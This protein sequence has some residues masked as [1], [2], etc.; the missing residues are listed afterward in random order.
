MWCEGGRTGFAALLWCLC[1]E[2]KHRSH[3]P[4]LRGWQWSGKYR[5]EWHPKCHDC[6]ECCL[7][8]RWAGT[9]SIS[10]AWGKHR[11]LKDGQHFP[12][13]LIQQIILVCCLFAIPWTTACQVPLFM[14]SGEFEVSLVLS[15]PTK[16]WSHK[17]P[18]VTAPCNFLGRT[19]VTVPCYSSVLFLKQRKR[20]EGRS[21]LNTQREAPS[22]ILAPL[23]VCFFFSPWACPM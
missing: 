6:P 12:H 9:L 18:S 4:A 22:P 14:V 15:C 1:N 3:G 19:S 13:S 23:F 11:P 16:I 20:R 7:W 8:G 2:P 17:R 5:W 10:G 21:T